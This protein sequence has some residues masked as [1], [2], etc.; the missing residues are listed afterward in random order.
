[1]ARPFDDCA[2]SA[3][4]ADYFAAVSFLPITKPATRSLIIDRS[5]FRLGAPVMLFLLLEASFPAAVTGP[6]TLYMATG[7]VSLPSERDP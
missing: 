1:M 3:A 6:C 5:I 4:S 7:L 2:A